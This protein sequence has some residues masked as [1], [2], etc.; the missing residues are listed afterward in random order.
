MSKFN[1]H[2]KFVEVIEKY[3]RNINYNYTIKISYNKLK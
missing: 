3:I 1:S 2:H